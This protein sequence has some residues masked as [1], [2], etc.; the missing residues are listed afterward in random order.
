MMIKHISTRLFRTR[1]L[2]WMGG[3]GVVLSLVGIWESGWQEKQVLEPLAA[4]AEGGLAG[5]PG[6]AEPSRCSSREQR[7]YY[8]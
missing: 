4:P 2:W 7:V 5:C 8:I 3:L 1:L 6:M